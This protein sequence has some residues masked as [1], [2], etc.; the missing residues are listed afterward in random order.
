MQSQQWPAILVSCSSCLA[1]LL[2]MPLTLPKHI[3]LCRNPVAVWLAATA[4]RLGTELAFASALF[5][6]QAMAVTCARHVGLRELP[7]GLCGAGQV[8][9]SLKNWM[10]LRTSCPRDLQSGAKTW[11]STMGSTLLDSWTNLWCLGHGA[12]RTMESCCPAVQSA[13]PAP[14]RAG[15]ALSLQPNACQARATRGS[16]GQAGLTTATTTTALPRLQEPR[17]PSPTHH[18]NCTWKHSHYPWMPLQSSHKSSMQPMAGVAGCFAI[19]SRENGSS[20]DSRRV[21]PTEPGAALA[22]SVQ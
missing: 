2:E 10:S 12:Q 6:D 11:K 14:P 13:P 21:L 9:A 19:N 4:Q 22:F 20:C 15:H 18:P 16:Q 3:C 17:Q 7:L 1:E 5:L 8:G